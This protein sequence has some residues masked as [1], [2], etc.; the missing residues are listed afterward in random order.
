MLSWEP[1]PPEYQNGLIRHYKIVITETETGMEFTHIAT[2][3]IFNIISHIHPF[4]TY[5]CTLSAV[6]NAEGPLSDPITVQA[7]PD[8]KSIKLGNKIFFRNY[9]YFSPTISSQRLPS[10]CYRHS[11]IIKYHIIQL[12]S[13]TEIRPKWN[14]CIIC[15]QYYCY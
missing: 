1:P 15:R 12:E 5:N 9:L 7:L 11:G 14:H 8:C 13:S 4:Y 6:T 10:K 2:A 3:L